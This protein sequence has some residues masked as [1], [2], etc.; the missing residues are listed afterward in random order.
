VKAVTD[1]TALLLLPDMAR[2]TE[3]ARTNL[4]LVVVFIVDVVDVVV[5]VVVLALVVTAS[6]LLLFCCAIVILCLIFDFSLF[7]L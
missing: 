3:A 4:P 1:P 5:A 6:L 7:F 2:S